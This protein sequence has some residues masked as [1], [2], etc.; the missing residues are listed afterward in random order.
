[1]DLT[2]L[3]DAELADHLNTVLNEQERRA[4]L[5]TTAAQVEQLTVRYIGIGGDPAILSDAVM[6]GRDAAATPMPESSA[7]EPIAPAEE[8]AEVPA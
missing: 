5:N 8:E 6:R 2:T 4:A 3:S 1:M 7:P